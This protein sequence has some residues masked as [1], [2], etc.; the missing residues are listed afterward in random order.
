MEL[1]FFSLFFNCYFFYNTQL[2]F[3]IRD[4]E[5]A[6]EVV[7]VVGVGVV[8]VFKRTRHTRHR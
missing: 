8:E 4:V 1:F 7:E 3:L 5:E 2:N 6:V